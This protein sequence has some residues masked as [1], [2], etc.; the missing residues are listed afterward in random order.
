M[1]KARACLAVA[2]LLLAFGFFA[3]DAAWA[4][5]TGTTAAG[6]SL[7]KNVGAGIGAGLA[8]VG[9]GLGVGRIGGSTVEA[10]ARQPEV[11]GQVFTPMI[12]TAAM[13]EGAGFFAVIVCLMAIE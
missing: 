9:V 6:T 4:E 5:G 13:V 1:S 12:I 8:I 10:I 2:C 3:A 7:M 11:T